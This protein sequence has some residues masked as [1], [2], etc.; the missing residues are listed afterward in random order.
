MKPMSQQYKRIFEKNHVANRYIEKI[1]INIEDEKKQ[2]RNSLQKNDSYFLFVF[3]GVVLSFFVF[4]SFVILIGGSTINSNNLPYITGIYCIIIL[5]IIIL[6]K[7]AISN[8]REDDNKYKSDK[9]RCA[10]EIKRIESKWEQR[11]LNDCLYQRAALICWAIDDFKRRY[12]IY[13]K[14]HDR[15][16]LGYQEVDETQAE[17][18]RVQ[19]EQIHDVLIKA[20]DNFQRAWEIKKGREDLT[21]K[22]ARLTDGEDSGALSELMSILDERVELVEPNL[23]DDDPSSI[24]EEYAILDELSSD[25]LE[26]RFKEIEEEQQEATETIPA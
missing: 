9:Q 6:L 7:K 4:F 22:Y 8:K 13:Q 11:K 10:T 17:E 5:I 15:V 16:D 12:H 23:N 25:D 1:D 19:L 3:A 14:W 2:K 20:L 18:I 24:L 21:T 26:R